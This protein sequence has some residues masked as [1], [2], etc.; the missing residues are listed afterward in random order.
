MKNIKFEINGS[1]EH[2]GLIP[3]PC[4]FKGKDCTYCINCA[5][6]NNAVTKKTYLRVMAMQGTL[7]QKYKQQM[8]ELV[9]ME[10]YMK[11]N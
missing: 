7:A 2:C 4:Y 11:S 9:E 3:G 6:A 8:A 10:F 1:C 5:F